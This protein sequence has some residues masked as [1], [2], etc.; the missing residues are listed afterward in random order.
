[1]VSG[2]L[3]II[4]PTCNQYIYLIEGLMYTIDKFWPNHGEVIIIGYDEP[5]FKLNERWS[6]ISLGT[7]TGPKDW[8]NDLIRFFKTFEDEFFINLI[9]DTLMT[10][11]ADEEQIEYLF[12]L[13]SNN[14]KIGKIFLHGSLISF[15]KFKTV[16]DDRYD[17]VSIN[18]NSQYRTSIQSAIWRKEYFLK[19]LKP[20]LTPWDFELQH[21]MNDGVEIIS[22][23]SN[24]PTMYSHLYRKGGVFQK[25]NWYKSVYESTELNTEDINKI[26]EML[27]L[28]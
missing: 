4:L 6:F 13:I 27:K 25:N 1:M 2:D 14:N 9:D 12:Q 24:H 8:S 18:Q 17:L 21:I 7:Q 23:N 26:K 16:N 22:T 28:G 19:L 15:G 10:R 3:K 20:N 11:P 5:K